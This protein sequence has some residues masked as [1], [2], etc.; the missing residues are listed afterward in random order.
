[1]KNT[2]KFRL[3]GNHVTFKKPLVSLTTLKEL[4]TL[5]NDKRRYLKMYKLFFKLRNIIDA[6]E[7]NTST[8]QSII[9]RSFKYHDFNS[10]RG[11]FLNAQPESKEAIFERMVNTLAFVFNSTVEIEH[12]KKEVLFFQDL[13]LPERTEKSIIL[14]ILTMDTQKPD[15]IK[16][17]FHYEWVASLGKRV[18]LIDISAANKSDKGFLR[19]NMTLIGFRQYETD[20]MRLNECYK[21]C[22]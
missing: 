12:P 21:L 13:D 1:M 18:S 3:D 20:L 8:Y 15:S 5:P 7:F 2:T 10:R 17:D 6:K 14:T 22:L 4:R 16:Y 11:V 19:Q 9:R